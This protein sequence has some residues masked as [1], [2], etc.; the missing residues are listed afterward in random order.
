MANSTSLFDTRQAW[1]D[2]PVEA[3]S[4][5]LL[6]PEFVLTKRGELQPLRASS[7]T[8]Y[9]SMGSRFAKAVVLD[10]EEGD[11]KGKPWSAI[12]TDDVRSFLASNDLKKGIRNRYVRLLEKLFDHLTALKLVDSNPARGLAIKEPSKSGQHHDKT[13]WLT[14]EQQQA[15]VEKLP[16]GGWKAQRNRALIATILGGGVKVSEVVALRVGAVGAR[17]E[18]GS[19]YLDVHP[20]G[21]GRQHRTKVSPFAAAYLTAWLKERKAFGL[22]GDVLFPAKPIGGMLHTTTVYRHVAGLL[23]EAGIAPFIIKRR[24]A[25]TLRNTFAVRELLN[26]QSIEA[27]GEFLGH[28]ADRSTLYYKALIK[29]ESSK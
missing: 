25:R 13:M 14:E 7:V 20:E 3:L 24:G 22:Q 15:V 4:A 8:V 17:Q 29:N 26:G 9:R 19:L 1:L 10:A 12:T 18:N 23:T 11:R 21:A 16:E 2:T 28:H 6:D 5:W 27:V